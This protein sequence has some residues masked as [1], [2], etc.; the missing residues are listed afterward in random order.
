[1]FYIHNKLVYIILCQV[2]TS[3]ACLMITVLCACKNHTHI[4]LYTEKNIFLKFIF[5]IKDKFNYYEK[6]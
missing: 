5:T 1:M 4:L 3:E 2:N 6:F